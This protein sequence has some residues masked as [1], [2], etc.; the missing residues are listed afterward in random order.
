MNQQYY[1]IKTIKSVLNEEKY[2]HF[3]TTAY[4]AKVTM[5]GSRYVHTVTECS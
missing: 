5:C 3:L 2:Q 4:F 1:V